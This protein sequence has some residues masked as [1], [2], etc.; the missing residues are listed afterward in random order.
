[1]TDAGTVVIGL[2]NPLMGDD[3]IGLAL[4]ARLTEGWDIE[5]AATLVD[6]GTWGM[7]LLPTIEDAG[8][9]ILL[10]AINVGT[11]PGTV[12]ELARH[13]IPRFLATKI[14]PHQVDLRDVLAVAEL[15]RTLPEDTIAIGLQP[16]V[17]ALSEMLTPVVRDRVDEAVAAVVGALELRGHRCTRREPAHA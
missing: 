8:R 5:P 17:V 15:R 6:G 4:L 7:N 3:G 1:M 9:L 11:A 16:A 2:G 12:V 13:R 10:D 14:S